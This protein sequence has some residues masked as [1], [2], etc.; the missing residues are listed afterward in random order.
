MADS[1][2][3]VKVQ[4]SESPQKIKFTT[5]TKLMENLN[6]VFPSDIFR[7]KDI[8]LSNRSHLTDIELSKYD[9]K[10]TRI[11]FYQKSNYGDGSTLNAIVSCQLLNK[12]LD[13][14]LFLDLSDCQDSVISSQCANKPIVSVRCT[15][16]SIIN[17]ESFKFVRRDF[18]KFQN[19]ITEK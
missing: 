6:K 4:K 14:E 3:N 7:S 10:I 16:E 17:N 11:Y 15:L 2:S 19:S 18:K 1:K 5:D 12:I 9:M 13:C 8:W